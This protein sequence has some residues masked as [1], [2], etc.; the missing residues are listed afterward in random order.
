MDGQSIE[1]VFSSNT[2]KKHEINNNACSAT[3]ACSATIPGMRAKLRTYGYKYVVD[4]HFQFPYL[5][6][7]YTYP[8]LSP[9]Y[10][11]TAAV[12]FLRHIYHDDTV[13]DMKKMR[14]RKNDKEPSNQ[15]K[16]TKCK[17][18]QKK[19]LHGGAELTKSF[20]TRVVLVACTCSSLVCA[21]ELSTIK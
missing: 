6:G 16:R 17:I 4:I 19:R 1:A 14:W 18:P 5:Y 11:L 15:K 12:A 9:Y 13:R 8:V 2:L 21:C 10:V 7:I 20:V 3:Y